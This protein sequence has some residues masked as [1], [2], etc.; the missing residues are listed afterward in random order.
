MPVFLLAALLLK[1][2]LLASPVFDGIAI[3]AV[4][5]LF[6][7]KLWL[8]HIKKPDFSQEVQ[9]NLD[10]TREYLDSKIEDMKI[11][12]MDNVKKLDAKLSGHV[13]NNAQKPSTTTYG[14]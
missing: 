10:A 3:T 11:T 5:V 2:V 7:F 8:D 4:S 9:E 14:W 13:L 1:S 12:H 6:G